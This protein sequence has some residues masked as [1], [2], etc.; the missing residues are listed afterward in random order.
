MF[1]KSSVGN[2]IARNND[3]KMFDGLTPF[4]PHANNESPTVQGKL[5]RKLSTAKRLLVVN[6]KHLKNELKWA[7]ATTLT[8]LRQSSK[9]LKKS[10]ADYISLVNDN[11]CDPEIKAP[12]LSDVED[13]FNRCVQSHNYTMSDA[14]CNPVKN[15]PVET[16]L[17]L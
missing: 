11:I 5:H 8:I 7:K 6:L 16:D 4:F 12:L 15:C 3:G 9:K 2:P 17:G 1:T 10:F 14:L 13:L